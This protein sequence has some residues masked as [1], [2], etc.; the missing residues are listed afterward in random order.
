MRILVIS[1]IHANL[2]AFETVLADAEGEWDKIWFLGD[3]VGYGPDPNECVALMQEYDHLALSGNH[4]WAILGKLD[5]DNFN[6]DARNAVL[7]AQDVI[8][9]ET[10]SYLN[11]LPPMILLDD[12]FTLAHASPRHPVWEYVLDPGTAAIN[13]DYYNTPYCLVGHTHVPVIFGQFNNSEQVEIFPPTYD[14]LVKLEGDPRCIINPGSVGQPRDSDP[15]AA[16]AI[17]NLE[18]MTWQHR[19]VAYDFEAVQARMRTHNL[20]ERL[21]ARLA[22]GW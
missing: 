3:L 16:Y 9:D 21:V 15:R 11:D 17:L 19:R 5:I 10:R 1:D 12:T 14:E 2:T 4:D 18:D 6:V 22:Y 7:W 13:F 8:T 20:S